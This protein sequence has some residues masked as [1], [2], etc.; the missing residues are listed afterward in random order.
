MTSRGRPLDRTRQPGPE[1]R[2]DNQTGAAQGSRR[3]RLD[4]A[5]PTLGRE[6]GVAAQRSPVAEQRHAH[7]PAALSQ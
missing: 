4:R 1:Y 6:R 5:V 2:V 3:E 7:R